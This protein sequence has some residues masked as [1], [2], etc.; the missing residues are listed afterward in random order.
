MSSLAPFE[1]SPPA[2]I[3]L[4]IPYV[5]YY[6]LKRLLL[7]GSRALRS[8]VTA[9]ATKLRVEVRPYYD[10]PAEAL[11]YPNLRS[12]VICSPEGGI[13]PAV[14]LPNLPYLFTGTYT[15]L[16]TL[17]LRFPLSSAVLATQIPLK[18]MTPNLTCLIIETSCHFVPAMVRNLP[19]S[20]IEL[21]VIS[22]SKWSYR[23][24]SASICRAAIE[25]LPNSLETLQLE[26][27][28]VSEDV[29]FET[30][31][32]TSLTDLLLYSAEDFSFIPGLPK[33]LTKLNCGCLV[34]EDAEIKVSDFPPRLTYLTIE[35]PGTPWNLIVD[36]PLPA[37]LNFLSVHRAIV[38]RIAENSNLTLE[39]LLPSSLQTCS[40]LN[41][42]FRINF[43]W[44]TSLPLL[45]RLI[46]RP[47]EENGGHESD[48]KEFPPLLRELIVKH[49]FIDSQAILKLPNTLT[50]IEIGFQNS[51]NYVRAFESLVNLKELQVHPSTAKPPRELWPYMHTR[52]Q[53]LDVYLEH[54]ESMQDIQAF[55]LKLQSL[56]LTVNNDGELPYD[57]HDEVAEEGAIQSNETRTPWRWP[58]G[59]QDFHLTIDNAPMHQLR[60]LWQPMDYLSRLTSLGLL[61]KGTQW[62]NDKDDTAFEIFKTLPPS[63]RTLYCDVPVTIGSEYF[64]SLPINL[65]RLDVFGF[66][67][68]RVIPRMLGFAHDPRPIGPSFTN[69]HLEHLPPNLTVLS[70]AG[71][72]RYDYEALANIIPPSV[73]RLEIEHHKTSHSF[74]LL[75]TIKDDL[76]QFYQLEE[77]I[78]MMD[79]KKKKRKG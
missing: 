30:R 71:H 29:T 76:Q 66:L 58:L 75:S 33:T 27:F 9:G 46:V 45:N 63:L 56:S 59:L 53:R 62:T 42:L 44:V 23:H 64:H 60:R 54:F 22:R 50:Y 68:M 67:Q 26:Q 49:T 55:S 72:G 32:P 40:P 2:L 31:W 57:L 39:T 48:P 18:E 13:A 11:Q 3:D 6:D 37:D 38:P 69:A 1:R 4:I 74:T 28:K 35:T 15:N 52:L 20:L 61:A 41:F 12:L 51:P 79:S 7:T 77:I 10:F 65:E 25:E 78:E 43:N 24:D 34:K 8:K 17:E 21:C 16:R 47:R 5:S 14:R 73:T 70:M 36:S 19:I